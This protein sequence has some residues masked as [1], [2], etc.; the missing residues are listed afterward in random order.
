MKSQAS[1]YVCAILYIYGGTQQTGPYI[2]K[3]FD[4]MVL[5]E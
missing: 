5:I 4:F 3:S 1:L 2:W